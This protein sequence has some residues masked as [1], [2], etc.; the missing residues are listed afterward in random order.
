MVLSTALFD[1]P[2]FKNCICHGV[3]LDISG[4][5]LSKRLNNYANPLDILKLYG[6]DALRFFMLSSHVLK[7]NDM[8]IDKDANVVKDVLRLTIKPLWSAYNFFILYA[9]SDGIKAEP[10]TTSPNLLDRYILYKLKDTVRAISDAMNSYEIALACDAVN[11]FLDVLNNWYIRRNRYRFW[12]EQKDADKFDAYNTLAYV[13]LSFSKATASLLPFICE[14][15][16]MGIECLSKNRFSGSVHL[17]S[18][19][20]LEN[21]KTEDKLVREIDQVQVICSTALSIRN[22]ENLKIR[23][24]LASMSVYGKNLDFLTTYQD[25]IKDEL[26]IKELIVSDKLDDVASYKLKLNFKN[27]AQRLP[28][29][30]KEIIAS[31]N[32]GEWEQTQGGL[33][34]VSGIELHRNEFDLLIA[35]KNNQAS[36]ATPNNE[37]LITLDTHITPELKA[38]GLARDLVR[39]IQQARKDQ[40]F[41]VS[42]H[43]NLII[44]STQEFN[45]QVCVFKK[46]IADQT[47]ANITF[48]NTIEA[49]ENAIESTIEEFKIML[50]LTQH[51]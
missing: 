12:Q 25:I 35:A 30:V 32:K 47:L 22:N 10:K 5:K 50:W 41:R 6:S 33:V 3:I 27:I 46:Y 9:N 24:P 13:L 45:E 29:K 44:Y 7:G 34:Q 36:A 1:R 28:S 15:I 4:Q 26:N 19:P 42:D 48:K 49:Q 16:Y 11:S 31:A 8:L 37:I 40:G 51:I 20:N 38:E 39:L 23:Q 21:I 14:E 43:I 18:Y 17:E 2:P